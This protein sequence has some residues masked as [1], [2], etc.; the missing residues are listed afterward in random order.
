MKMS[1][2]EKSRKERERREKERERREEEEKMG[3]E[4]KK[5]VRFGICNVL[6]NSSTSINQAK[7]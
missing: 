1:D 3:E 4:R 7:I 2:Y 6:L 5:Q